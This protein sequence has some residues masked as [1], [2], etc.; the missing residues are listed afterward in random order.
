MIQSRAMTGVGWALTA[1]F[2]LFIAF[3]VGIKL[4]RRPEVAE[5]LTALGWP[6]R[7]GLPSA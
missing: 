1:M 2:L 7:H 5:T 4:A 3:D 6:S